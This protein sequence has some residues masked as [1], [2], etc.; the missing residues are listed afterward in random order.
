MQFREVAEMV[1]IPRL[2]IPLFSLALMFV[3][4]AASAQAVRS[5]TQSRPSMEYTIEQFLNTVAIN[6]ASFSSDE[7]RILVSSDKTGIWNVYSVA[8]NGGE[9]MPVT[10]R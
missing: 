10:R 8:V 6:G 3:A 1:V 5:S 4:A 7:T 9:L 2:C